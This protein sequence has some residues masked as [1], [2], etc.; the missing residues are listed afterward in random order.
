MVI[1]VLATEAPGVMDGGAKVQVAYWGS[2]EQLNCTGALKPPTGASEMVA[3]PVWPWEMVR[4]VLL[5]DRLNVLVAATLIVVV[6]E[7]TVE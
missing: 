3:V 2:P 1:V 6:A 7:P 5:D 4:L